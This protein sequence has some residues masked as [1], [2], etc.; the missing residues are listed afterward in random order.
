M[1]PSP[2]DP[3]VQSRRGLY[4]GGSLSHCPWGR[5]R[6]RLLRLYFLSQL[7]SAYDHCPVF[8]T[9]VP[10]GRGNRFPFSKRC[11]R[12]RRSRP[13]PPG[14]RFCTP[15]PNRALAVPAAGESGGGCSR[16]SG[17]PERGVEGATE[18]PVL[19]I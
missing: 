7:A 4:G 1:T 16:L 3:G 9:L 12:P 6:P 13:D 8:P 11:L 18:N 17:G 19:V 10:E 2:P 5:T 14:N 15:R